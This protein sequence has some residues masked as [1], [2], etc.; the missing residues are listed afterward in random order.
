MSK[1]PYWVRRQ[2][3]KDDKPPW[4]TLDLARKMWGKMPARLFP[5]EVDVVPVE[6]LIK[7][8]EQHVGR[9]HEMTAV[10]DPGCPGTLTIC[11]TNTEYGISELDPKVQAVL[12]RE[13]GQN[14]YYNVSVR[15]WHQLN[16][17]EGTLV[18]G[19]E[20]AEIDNRELYDTIDTVRYTPIKMPDCGGT[21]GGLTLDDGID[22]LVRKM[23]HQ[24][25][26]GDLEPKR[27]HDVLYNYRRNELDTEGIAQQ[28]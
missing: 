1:D 7:R 4:W 20:V 10:H 26:R 17:Q 25:N 22:L 28:Q 9:T 23:H 27:W 21:E 11:V 5:D 14:Y 6:T 18:K 3:T 19:S 24:I 2:V 15:Y 13:N 12:R 16:I 8:F